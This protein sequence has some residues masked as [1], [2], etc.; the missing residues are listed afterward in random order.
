M[1]GRGLLSPLIA[2]A[3]FS[4]FLPLQK[5]SYTSEKGEVKTAKGYIKAIDDDALAIKK[6]GFIYRKKKIKYLAIDTVQL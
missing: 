2:T 3:Y 1:K 4:L 6:R 5:S